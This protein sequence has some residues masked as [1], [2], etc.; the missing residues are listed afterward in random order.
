M[1]NIIFHD[2]ATNWWCKQCI[3][4]GFGFGFD[5]SLRKG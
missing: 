1:A 5:Y 2:E 3:G 4:F